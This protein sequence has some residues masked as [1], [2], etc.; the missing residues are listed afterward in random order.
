VPAHALS[1]DVSTSAGSNGRSTKIRTFNPPSYLCIVVGRLLIVILDLDTALIHNLVVQELA[2]QIDTDLSPSIGRTSSIRSVSD[3]H[4]DQPA[5]ADVRYK[6]C[7]ARE[8]GGGQGK[9]SD[10][11]ILV[12]LPSFPKN[13]RTIVWI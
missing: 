3:H 11:A 4:G 2:Q 10:A 6:L 5:R 13:A 1:H 12:F 7:K 8:D 9:L